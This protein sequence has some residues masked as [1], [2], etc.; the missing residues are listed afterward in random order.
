MTVLPQCVV[1][2]NIYTPLPPREKFRGEGGSKKET[3][4][5]GVG[6]AYSR[7]FLRGLMKIGELLII[8]SFSVEQEFSYFTVIGLQNKYYCLD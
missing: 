8:K 5:K 1:P 3:I 2:E 6:V 4:A 7:F